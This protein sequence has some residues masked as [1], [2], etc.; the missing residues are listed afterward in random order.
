MGAITPVKRD[1]TAIAM[2]VDR[3]GS[4]ECVAEDTKGGVKQFIADQKRIDG[5][6]SFTL[7]QFDHE[8]EVLHNFSD[9][10]KVDENAFAKQYA[11][12]GSTA[13][14][15]AIG[16]TV[17]EMGQKIEKMD[18]PERPAHVI[19]AIVTDGQE[20]ASCEFTVD[21]IKKLIEEKQA[22]DWDFVFLGADLN[23]I[24]VAQSYGF[25]PSQSAYYKSSNICGAFKSICEQ[26]ISVR[27]GSKVSFSPDDRKGLAASK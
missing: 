9:L 7:V 1:Y 14:L 13:L 2:V 20:N 19:V 17:L 24:S 8:Y 15:D 6:A 21:K 4:M 27:N 10:G 5:K 25:T 11:P 26:V 12:R 18:Q 22:K 3:S 16:K 23:A